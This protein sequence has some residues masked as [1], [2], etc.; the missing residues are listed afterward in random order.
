[1]RVLRVLAEIRDAFLEMMSAES[2]LGEE[3]NANMDIS[4]IEEQLKAGAYDRAS[5]EN[6]I[7][8]SVSVIMRLQ[9]PS[10]TDKMLQ[11]WRVVGK[12]MRDASESDQARKFC[13]ALKFILD[14]VGR[15]R[16]DAAND[17]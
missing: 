6:L 3:V 11:E 14:C 10:R 15:M 13:D 7:G 9:H 8:F 4:H 16:I 2:R 5:S 1:M 17:R 12:A